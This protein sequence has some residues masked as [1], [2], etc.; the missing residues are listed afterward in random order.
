VAINLT[1]MPMPCLR[2]GKE[3]DLTDDGTGYIACVCGAHYSAELINE[4]NRPGYYREW[5]TALSCSCGGH[6]APRVDHHG[7]KRVILMKRHR[8]TRGGVGWMDRGSNN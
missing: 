4:N 8:C 6:L 1:Y 7:D 2:C 3:L 5:I